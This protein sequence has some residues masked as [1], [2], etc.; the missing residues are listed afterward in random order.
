[1]SKS[2]LQLEDCWITRFEFQSL[3]AASNIEIAEAAPKL[4]WET[5]QSAEDASYLIQMR[6]LGGDASYRMLLNL[7]ATFSFDE[8]I[9]EEMRGRMVNL[10]GPAIIYGVARG[11]V[12]SISGL[13]PTRRVI[14]PSVNIVNI[15]EQRDKRRA[16]RRE[17]IG[18]PD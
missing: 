8:S 13:S 12:A 10:N 16:R 4:S 14:L 6:I 18:K 1:M 15:A 2:G 5:K 17:N 11:I 3:G 7:S 9:D